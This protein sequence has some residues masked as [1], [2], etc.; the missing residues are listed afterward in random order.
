MRASASGVR[1]KGRSGERER[2]PQEDSPLSAE[3]NA[4]LDLMS[5]RS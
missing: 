1:G 5:L 2:E 4:G 3:T